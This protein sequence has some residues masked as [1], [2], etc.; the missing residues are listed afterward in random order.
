MNIILNIKRIDR[1][2]NAT[3]YN[4]TNAASLIEKVRVRQLKF[5]GHILRLPDEELCKAFALYIQH[6]VRE[7]LEGNEPCFPD[8][9]NNFLETAMT[10]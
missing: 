8:I 9:Y 6:M 7:N 2:P 5:L 1:I 10:C 3:I 4:L